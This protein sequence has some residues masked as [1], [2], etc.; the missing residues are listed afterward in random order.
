MKQIVFIFTILTFSNL[1]S[2]DL[3]FTA[4][5]SQESFGL[6][7]TNGEIVTKFPE[8][9]R[10]STIQFSSYPKVTQNFII[11]HDEMSS[12]VFFLNKKGEVIKELKGV[13]DCYSTIGTKYFFCSNSKKGEYYSVLLN[14]NGDKV[15]EGNALNKFL[16]E[17]DKLFF[18]SNWS[19][20]NYKILDLKNLKTRTFDT[21]LN[22][23]HQSSKILRVSSKGSSELFGFVDQNG[24]P[25]TPL[26]YISASVFSEGYALGVLKDLSY[27]EIINNKGL[28]VNRIKLNTKTIYPDYISYLKVANNIFPF[29]E[30]WLEGGKSDLYGYL[31]LNGNWAIKPNYESAESYSNGFG[32]VI[33]IQNGIWYETIINLKGTHI[34]EKKIKIPSYNRS[35]KVDNN[36][37]F[38]FEYST[39]Y[40]HKGNQIFRPE[41]PNLSIFDTQ[42]IGMVDPTDIRLIN[43]SFDPFNTKNPEKLNKIITKLKDCQNVENVTINLNNEKVDLSFLEGMKNIRNFD[44]RSRDFVDFKEHLLSLK[45]IETLT[46]GISNLPNLSIEV[47]DLPKLKKIQINNY[48]KSLQKL[49]NVFLKKAKSL[50]IVVN[51][52]GSKE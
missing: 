49:S 5:K 19:E 2:Q 6:I 52:A 40:N 13:T 20:K 41:K 7:N 9:Y 35:L 30:I 32:N 34:F 46:I 48:N 3:Y 36:L 31:D 47:L 26:N 21:D 24:K 18:K 25:V 8:N 28:I 45:N 10:I 15:W 39:F 33:S 51:G 14:L 17:N 12:K 44:L 23:S 43:I 4:L 29:K 1:F 38:D 16:V 27:L 50:G 11:A 37:I 22:F 42:L